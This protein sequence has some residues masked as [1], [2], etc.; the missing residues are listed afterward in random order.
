ME[1]PISRMVLGS[2]CLFSKY[3]MEKKKK[4][5]ALDLWKMVWWCLSSFLLWWKASYLLLI[6][7]YHVCVKVMHVIY[8]VQL[9]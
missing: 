2:E 1:L 8:G 4:M 5:V 6:N 7:M 3:D 9:W